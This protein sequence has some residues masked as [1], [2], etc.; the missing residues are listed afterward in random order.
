MQADGRH[1][2]RAHPPLGSS[3]Q[4]SGIDAMR[5]VNENGAGTAPHSTS[6][7]AGQTTKSSAHDGS[8]PAKTQLS[9]ASC[10]VACRSFP[11]AASIATVKTTAAVVRIIR[12]V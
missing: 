5:H 11:H 3:V 1:H 12:E 6:K 2:A 4:Q 9:P 8:V 10:G 7:P